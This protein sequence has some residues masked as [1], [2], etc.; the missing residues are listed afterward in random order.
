MMKRDTSH[1]QVPTL[2][3]IYGGADKKHLVLDKDVTSV[4]RARGCDLTLDATEVSAV[5]CLFYRSAAGYRI[6]DC[7]SRTGTR[8]NGV[9]VKNLPVTDGD[10][11]QIGP[12][13]FEVKLPP[14][15]GAQA[16]VDSQQLERANQSRRNLARLALQLRRQLRQTPAGRQALPGTN[17]LAER[18]NELKAEIRA[19]EERLQQLDQSDGDLAEARGEIDKEREAHRQHVHQVENNLA[20]RVQETEEAVRAQW[21]EFQQRCAAEEARLQALASA[22][23]ANQSAAATEEHETRRRELAE[24]EQK[25]KQREAAWDRKEREIQNDYEEVERERQAI[26]K[27]RAQVEAEQRQKRAEFQRDEAELSQRELGLREQKTELGRMLSDLKRLQ[28]EIKKQPRVDTK[29]LQHENQQLRQTVS[30]LQQ[31]ISELEARL[32]EAGATQPAAQAPDGELQALRAENEELRNLLQQQLLKPAQASTDD[33]ALREENQQLRQI[34]TEYEERLAADVASSA[35]AASASASSAAAA[36]ASGAGEAELRAENDLLRQ[37]LQEKDKF[38]D[39][40]RA[41]AHAEASELPANV[42]EQLEAR[43]QELE[44]LRGAVVQLEQ[45]VEEARQQPQAAPAAVPAAPPRD[46]ADLESYETELNRYRQQLEADRAKLNQEIQ[47]L[48]TR[49]AELD[50]A[51]REMEMELSRERAEMARER[52]RLDRLREEIKSEMER[53]Q[54]DGGVRESLASF[55]RLRDE[56][57]SGGG[58]R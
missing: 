10:I 42:R 52:I 4:G 44:R 18:A 25:L 43:D 1:G 49:N 21:I 19:C 51:T 47:A 53:V 15:S 45:Q 20:A 33:A 6:R 22:A 57:R 46:D 8:L 30:D 35:S 27:L 17:G 37:L 32:P 56:V 31:T 7:G 12:F 3:P 48:R 9:P 38:L 23:V 2:T 29:P 36:D 54:R 40:I 50:E 55:Q 24:R 11:L 14:G 34:L 58:R 26:I 39:E 16:K 28:E 13:S 5:H 41:T